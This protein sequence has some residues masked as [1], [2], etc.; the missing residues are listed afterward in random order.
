MA[1]IVVTEQP[2]ITVVKVESTAN[3][4]RADPITNTVTVQTTNDIVTVVQD[5]IS[6]VTVFG[7]SPNTVL[8]EN[9]VA[10]AQ[11]IDFVGDT[12]IYRAEAVPGT[13]DADPLWRIRRITFVNPEEDAITEWATGVG[14]FIHVWDDRLG[15][16]YT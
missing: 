1:D 13:L 15:L 14:T 4:V 16:S 6:V 9:D 8:S 2:V 11:R 10:F 7:P 5:V 12:L 3:V